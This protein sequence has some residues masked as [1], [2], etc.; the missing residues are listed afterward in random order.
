MHARGKSFRYEA[1]FPD[2]TREI[3][4]DVPAYDVNLQ[5]CYELAQPR[6]LPIGTLLHCTAV[7]DNSV[8]NLAN[9]DPDA[10]VRDGALT[11]DEMFN[12]FFDITLVD[13]DIA[14]ESA[15]EGQIEMRR[16]WTIWPAGAAI[17][18]AILFVGGKRRR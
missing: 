13:Q 2:G 12:A 5:R 6:R 11:K 10:T 15:T 14:G 9:P 18:I 4:L 7:Y 8:D 1:E 17:V 3:L 16:C